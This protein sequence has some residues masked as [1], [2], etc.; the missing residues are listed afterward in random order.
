MFS[1]VIISPEA[2]F[3]SVYD[4]FS[5]PLYL[6][7]RKILNDAEEAKDQTSDVFMKLWEMREL[8]RTIGEMKSYAFIAARNR[9]INYLILKQRRQDKQDELMSW[10]YEFIG[11]DVIDVSK[12]PSE[13]A[14]YAAIRALDGKY[15]QFILLHYFEEMSYAAIAEALG[16]SK[17]TVRYR[18]KT[19]RELLKAALQ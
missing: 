2:I 1:S 15:R 12:E 14:L 11:D 4:N 3:V 13:L 8:F 5:E 6:F 16:V 9:S 7:I 19:G 10:C 18:I 17:P